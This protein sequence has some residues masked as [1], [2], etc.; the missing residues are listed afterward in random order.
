M[1]GV[2]PVM[3]STSQQKFSSPVKNIYKSHNIRF[4]IPTLRRRTNHISKRWRSAQAWPVQ[5]SAVFHQSDRPNLIS[6]VL[7]W[8]ETKNPISLT[9]CIKLKYTYWCDI[10][11]SAKKSYNRCTQRHFPV[12]N[13]FELITNGR[14]NS[15]L[16]RHHWTDAKH[17]KHK[18]KQHWKDL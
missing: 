3:N 1:D 9:L 2:R 7:P 16:Q 12:G 11:K 13:P 10:S 8:I 5:I 14:Y 4:K 6:T 15:T 18:E 17:K